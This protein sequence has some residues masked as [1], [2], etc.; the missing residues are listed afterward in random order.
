M[1]INENIKRL[2]TERG[3]T[4]QEV[5]DKL[6]VTRQCISRWEG[7]KTLP[8]IK[9]IE[10]L[11]LVFNCSINDI[12]EEDT[13]KE[14]TLFTTNKTKNQRT[15]VFMFGLSFFFLLL[16]LSLS[17]FILNKRLEASNNQDINDT[18]AIIHEID[19]NNYSIVVSTSQTDTTKYTLIYQ[20]NQII[21]NND[22]KPINFEHLGVGDLIYIEYQQTLKKPILKR[23]ILVDK[24]TD[25]NLL[26]VA[27]VT[28]GKDYETTD[29][30][31]ND[32]RN[33]EEGIRYY[34]SHYAKGTSS[35]NYNL[36]FFEANIDT[37]YKYTENNK[38]IGR[39]N[40]IKLNIYYDKD[41]LIHEPK[42]I[43][44]YDTGLVYKEISNAQQFEG[45]FYYE[46]KDPYSS[47]TITFNFDVYINEAEAY[48][49]I[50]VYEYDKNNLLIKETT[51]KNS[52]DM[53]LYE[54]ND[55]ALYA[56]I[57][58]SYYRSYNQ[59]NYQH[60]KT[61]HKLYLGDKID[62]NQHQSFGLVIKSDFIY[63]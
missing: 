57:E 17:F 13:L 32:I 33:Y 54:P 10:Q 9:S 61:S 39:H 38:Y 36:G 59:Y 55:E 4:Q 27:Y 31:I 5:A 53:L 1:N 21:Y 8:D 58:I 60:Y 34:L 2:R 63:Q 26:G 16:L 18:Y 56:L 35:I 47:S 20:D 44:I 15:Y 50:T 14:L 12:F 46:S 48:E 30:L 42:L 62:I 19:E 25:K 45:S 6:F 11:A 41:K 40:D 28:N 3:L 22:L 37:T 52:T 29:E 7:G 23:I 51:I 49:E 24:K 43:L